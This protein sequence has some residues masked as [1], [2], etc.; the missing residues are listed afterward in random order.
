MWEKIITTWD[1][2]PKS[3]RVLIYVSISTILAEA[4]IEIGKFEQTFFIR[5]LAQLINLGIVFI[6]DLITEIKAL[7]NK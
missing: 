1:S 6:Q 3:A 4:I 5:V 7:T 2:L